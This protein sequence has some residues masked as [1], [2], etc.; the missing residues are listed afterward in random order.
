MKEFK[1]KKIIITGGAQGIGLALVESFAEVGSEV[2]FIDKEKI[3]GQKLQRRFNRTNKKVFFYPCNLSDF[4]KS[5]KLFRKILKKHK[6][7]NFLI[8]NAKA[9]K[10]NEVLKEKEKNW[11]ESIDVILKNSFFFSQEFI[12]QN[13]YNKISKAIL[14]ITSVV[15]NLISNESPSYH[16]AKSGLEGITKYLASHAGKFGVRVNSIAP[17]FVIQKRHYKKF[18]GKKNSK[19]RNLILGFHPMKNFGTE[20]DII[21]A[22][23][24]LLSN[25]SKFINGSSISLDGALSKNSYLQ[26]QKQIE[27]SKK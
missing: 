9:G 7:I 15:T 12:K 4:A 10:R 18:F 25:T 13:R 24:F 21:K 17:G 2:I 5:I 22:A 19:Y 16:A 3:K 27:P 6:N 8:N 20:N 11:S 14:N 1:D 23:F 26:L